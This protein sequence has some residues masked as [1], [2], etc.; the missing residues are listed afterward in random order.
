MTSVSKRTDIVL[1]FAAGCV[2][3]TA[4]GLIAVDVEAQKVLFDTT[5]AVH[6]CGAD[7]GTLRMVDVSAPCGPAQKSMFVKKAA[8]DIDYNDQTQGKPK[9]GNDA[10]TSATDQKKLADL[11]QKIAELENG[12]NREIA[13]K[14]VAPFWVIDRSGKLI[15]DVVSEDAGPQARL[16][17]GSGQVAVALAANSNGGQISVGNSSQRTYV[18]VFGDGAGVRILDASGGQ[19]KPRVALGSESGRYRLKILGGGGQSVAGIGENTLGTG[20]AQVANAGGEVKAV[21]A[22]DTGGNGSF[23]IYNGGTRLAKLSQGDFG[24]GLLTLW[25]SGGGSTPM[26]AAGT[27]DKGN[28]LVQVGPNG[29]KAG[30]GFFGLP[31]SFISGK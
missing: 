23:E 7:D 10:T 22:V 3:T 2:V 5:T 28:G 14:V 15:F 18:G 1:S 17:D 16:Y 13:H 27:T 24:G 26:V 29:F 6:I 21:M 30:L 11:E 25:R 8:S 19:S 9:S 20:T 12:A 4:M 31:G